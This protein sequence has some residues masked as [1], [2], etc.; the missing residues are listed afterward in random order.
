MTHIFSFRYI[1]SQVLIASTMSFWCP[2][3]SI[4]LSMMM[5]KSDESKERKYNDAPQQ[6]FLQQPL[7]LSQIVHLGFLFLNFCNS[8]NIEIICT[9]VVDAS[10]RLSS[11][12]WEL[13]SECSSWI[14]FIYCIL[15]PSIDKDL[16][17]LKGSDYTDTSSS[18]TTTSSPEFSNELYDR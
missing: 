8:F 11:E 17:F 10:C 12:R 14:T 18:H 7:V 2:G 15:Q 1:F 4:I 6:Y 5:L 3:V 13:N 9:W 16:P